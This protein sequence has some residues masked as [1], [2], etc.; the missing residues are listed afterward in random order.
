M[1]D[2]F[3]A[4]RSFVSSK[5]RMSN[6]QAFGFGAFSAILAWIF[7]FDLVVFALVEMCV[8][9]K[10]VQEGHGCLRKRNST[11]QKATVIFLCLLLFFYIPE[12][13]YI[14]IIELKYNVAYL[15]PIGSYLETM[16]W[17]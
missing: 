10:V 15:Y 12:K 7:L 9:K 17:K 2:V 11:C 6:T 3:E 16:A 4:A 13:K 14:Y 8:N 5:L 1:E